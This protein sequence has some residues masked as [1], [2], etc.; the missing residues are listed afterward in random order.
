MSEIIPIRGRV[1]TADVGHGR[2]PWLVVSNNARNT[3]LK[4]C[5]ATRIT[6]STKPPLP[7]IVELS[8]ADPLVG[9]VLCDDLV[10]LYR[11]ELLEDR[12]ALSHHTMVKVSQ[13][14]RAALAI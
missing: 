5:L 8:T 2:K 7:S 14:L 6:T 1:Y 13:G 12:G 10:N 3:R 4:D 9:R 11:D